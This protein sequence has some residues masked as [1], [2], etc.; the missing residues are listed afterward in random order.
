MSARKTLLFI[1]GNLYTHHMTIVR[2]LNCRTHT[3][4]H[5]QWYKET[6]LRNSVS[7]KKR[8]SGRF[9]HQHKCEA[10]IILLT[11]LI[12]KFSVYVWPQQKQNNNINL[13]E[14]KEA[15]KWNATRFRF[16]YFIFLLFFFEFHES[17]SLRKNDFVLV[18]SE[19]SAQTYVNSSDRKLHY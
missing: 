5:K 18:R 19:W 6:E 16:C 3:Q 1:H 8:K 10:S 4:S 2:F 13:T 17:W 15:T 11:N 12:K 9:L 7:Q 14:R